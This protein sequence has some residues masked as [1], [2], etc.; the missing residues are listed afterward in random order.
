MDRATTLELPPGPRDSGGLTVLGR[1]MHVRP[2]QLTTPGW[3]QSW[4]PAACACGTL[5]T[6]AGIFRAR[7]IASVLYGCTCRDTV[8]GLKTLTSGLNPSGRL[9][10]TTQA[11]TAQAFVPQLAIACK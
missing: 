9:Y 5:A 3:Q 11:V 8:V 10:P 4:L 2:V 6:L 1:C 7:A